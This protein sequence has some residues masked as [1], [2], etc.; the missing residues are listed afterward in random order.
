MTPTIDLQHF[1][2]FVPDQV[3][4]SQNLNDL[5]SYLDEQGR[6]TRT[7]L[8][9]IGIVCGLEIKMGNDGNGSFITI[10]K[11]TGVTSE[12]YL[13]T[14][15]ETKYHRFIDFKAEQPRFY[16]PLVNLS[17][18][19]QRFDIWELKQLSETTNTNLLS[20]IPNGLNNKVV[21]LFVELLESNNKNC[22][23]NSCD[24]KGIN[25]QV[26]IRPLLVNKTDA[27]GLIASGGTEVPAFTFNDLLPLRMPRWDVPN[28]GPVESNDILNAYRKVLSAT[29]V[30][31]VETA[32]T[33]AYKE[34]KPFIAHEYP[35]DPFA[36]LAE[37]MAF[38]Q[39]PTLTA[40]QTLHIQYY[41]D[42]FSDLLQAYEEFCKT[43]KTIYSTCC[44]DQRLFPRHLL[45]GEVLPPVGDEPSE[46][47]H[48]FLYSP[49]FE[50]KHLLF[51]LRTLFERMDMMVKIFDTPAVAVGGNP[52][53]DLNIRITP[54]MLGPAPLS[55][56]AIPY[57]YKINQT[58]QALYKYWNPDKKW[59]GHGD[60]V[61]SYHAGLY[62]SQPHVKDPLLYDWEPYN[63]LRVEGIVGKPIT[64]VL[65]NVQ[66]RI[67]NNRLPIQV[68]ALRT[69]DVDTSGTTPQQMRCDTKDLEINYDVARREWEAI[70]GKTIEYIDD[71]L[72]QVPQLLGADKVAPLNA[73]KADLHLAKTYMVDN[74]HVFSNKYR[75]FM[76]VFD[77][78]ETTA[79]N[80]RKQYAVLLGQQTAFTAASKLLEDM[81]DHF[82]EVAMSCQKGALRAV[83][84]EYQR[85]IVD[86]FGKQF[87]GYYAQHNPGIQHKAGA[88]VGGTFILVYH[89]KPK[90][91][92]LQLPLGTKFVQGNF[93][94]SGRI[95]DL[96]NGN[97][98][99]VEVLDRSSGARSVTN[100]GG[101]YS[102]QLSRLPAV[103]SLKASG[104]VARQF[105]VDNPQETYNF[106][107]APIDIKDTGYNNI[108]DGIVIADFFVPYTCCSDCAPIQFVLQDPPPN[109]PP[110]A[111][112]GDDISIRLPQNTVL[113]DGTHSKDPEGRLNS[114]AWIQ[115]TGPAP[116]TFQD[117]GLAVTEVTGLLAGDYVFELMVKD[118]EGE[119]STDEVKVT[120][121]DA[122]N[123]PPVVN[124]GQNRTIT[125]GN[126]LT[127]AG[128]ASDP[129]SN[130][131]PTTVWAVKAGSPSGSS[132]ANPNSLTT[133][134][135]GLVEGTYTFVLSATDNRGATVSD[136]V[137]IV[138]QRLNQAPTVTANASPAS[139]IIPSVGATVTSQ[140]VGTATDPNNDPF[141]LKWT[142]VSG[143]IGGVTLQSDTSPNTLA[144][145]T[146]GGIYIF[147]LTATDSR[148][149][150][151]T[152]DVTVT[153]QAANR[154]PAVTA[155][156]TTPN[157]TLPLT[158]AVNGQLSGTASDP[159][160]GDTI[161][162]AWTM[163]SGTAGGATIQT[164]SALNTTVA[165]S[166]SGTYVFRLTAIDNKGASAFANVTITVNRPPQV[167]ASTSTPNVTIPSTSA[168][169]NG[170]LNGTAS[171]PDT[172]DTLTIA[173]SIQSGTT[174]G[175]SIQTPSA[176]N[177]TV[178]FSLPGTYVFRLTATDNKGASSFANITINVVRQANQPP[179][180]VAS[181][182]PSFVALNQQSRG[183]SSLRGT[184]ST[185]PEGGPLTFSWSRIAGPT[186]AAIIS[187]FSS[188]TTV[189]FFTQGEY[190]FRLRVTDSNNQFDDAFVNVS[191]ERIDLFTGVIGGLGG[192]V[193]PIGGVVA[194]DGGT[195]VRPTAAP[196][197]QKDCGSFDQLLQLAID[198]FSN[199]TASGF[200]Q[201]PATVQ[202]QIKEFYEL[203]AK[204][205]LDSLTLARKLKLLTGQEMESKL[206]LWI[207]ET[208]KLI[209]SSD[210]M[211]MQ[212][213]MQLLNLHA[214]LVYHIACVQPGDIN[215]TKTVVKMADPV[216]SLLAAAT[217]IGSKMEKLDE[218]EKQPMVGQFLESTLMARAQVFNGNETESKKD[219]LKQ[220]QAILISFKL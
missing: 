152:A 206:K 36:N 150:S 155:S 194:R 86:I 8:I 88:P 9:G 99:N 137:V 10:T 67:D 143:T 121:L 128:T 41:Y 127:L 47:R 146:Q 38:L 13:V 125:L 51:N 120:V 37:K 89:M 217:E 160:P 111:R 119:S 35:N 7:N 117:A 130:I 72:P 132:F 62:G 113:L 183:S 95:T 25:V 20:S 179:N 191:A 106:K 133:A 188:I 173:W 71:V 198:V 156:T 201:L 180:A 26:N 30:Q 192:V 178:V 90:P 65:S 2:V 64:N 91:V 147:R 98:I 200:D 174:N 3:L 171:D 136:E 53:S 15:A 208:V 214:K 81:I 6:I 19:K 140:L 153:V 93:V 96:L 161:T 11:G 66:Q 85:R 170:Q 126:A 58:T 102:I 87:F 177:T 141:I 83:Y 63:F 1:P 196:T 172:G 68:I 219:Y 34:F 195:F 74:L 43:C 39:N 82:D 186:S 29:F 210:S 134:V 131:A 148:G 107:L 215:E 197:I 118:D 108:A 33:E 31:S 204:Q 185:D 42:F 23:P 115:K 220:L 59:R 69:G 55:D 45:L 22:D 40:A 166:Q 151:G 57:Y 142:V 21:V 164:P 105:M 27:A 44:P 218:A 149:A 169:A 16:E 163:V 18:K 97:L 92:E 175:A 32:L 211:A 168:T 50:C 79:E 181:A 207:D 4:T 48:H 77:R 189:Q 144:T 154:P 101:N 193:S 216:N 176:P 109:K 116:A 110:V 145:F 123:V 112:A 157:L 73:F 158:T 212:A 12:G 129:D 135:N 139:L 202:A 165:F 104:F 56:K 14:V 5:F 162:T 52:T 46:F 28:T 114:Y 184:S 199:V 94:I 182:T 205:K 76:G 159:D 24:D 203:G 17:T 84:Q 100:A 213:L 75:D 209:G 187:P 103:L 78:V 167:T 60:Q 190:Q 54:S 61:L 49:L 80:L 122:F 138:V 124:A 70:I